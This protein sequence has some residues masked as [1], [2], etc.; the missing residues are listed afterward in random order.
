MLPTYKISWDQIEKSCDILANKVLESQWQC[1]SIVGIS[2]GGSI[3]ATIIAHRLGINRLYLVAYKQ[4]K[5]KLKE[6]YP[7]HQ[8]LR[9]KTVLLIDDIADSGNTLQIVKKSL[10]DRNCE[11]RTL[12]IHK[13]EDASYIPDY[14]L[15]K[16]DSL[17][18]YP[19]ENN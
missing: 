7:I 3:P 13:R 1:S 14:F 10:E 18:E 2:R 8:D 6:V 15:Y 16:I 17:I 9:S 11:V 19:W 4:N 5:D 12:S